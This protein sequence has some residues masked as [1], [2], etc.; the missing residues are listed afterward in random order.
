M[1]DAVALLTKLLIWT[2]LSQH[3]SCFSGTPPS[4]TKKN[5]ATIEICLETVTNIKIKFMQNSGQEEQL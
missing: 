1:D 5:K 4:S 2:V 3:H